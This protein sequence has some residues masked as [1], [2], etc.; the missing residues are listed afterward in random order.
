MAVLVQIFNAFVFNSTP[1]ESNIEA[2]VPFSGCV[3]YLYPVSKIKSMERKLSE[4]KWE[5]T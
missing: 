3:L 2:P 1:Y 4:E 5:G